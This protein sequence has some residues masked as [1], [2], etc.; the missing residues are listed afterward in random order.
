M[1]DRDEGGECDLV[2]RYCGVRD[3]IDRPPSKARRDEALVAPGV[4]IEVHTC[5]LV[6]LPGQLGAV[7]PSVGPFIWEDE[8]ITGPAVLPVLKFPPEQCI[9]HLRGFLANYIVVG[10]RRVSL[11]ALPVF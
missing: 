8:I 2:R 9:N 4:A 1:V 6:D 10:K 3:R 7:Q 5:Q 11:A